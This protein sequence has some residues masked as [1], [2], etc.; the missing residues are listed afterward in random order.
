MDG[1]RPAGRT[2]A[3]VSESFTAAQ[4]WNL[5]TGKDSRVSFGEAITPTTLRFSPGAKLLGQVGAALIPVGTAH[6]DGQPL[7]QRDAFH[8]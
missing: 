8:Q 3:T 7:A 6:Q 1:V 2:L 4:V 5:V